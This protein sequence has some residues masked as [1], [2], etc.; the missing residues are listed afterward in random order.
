MNRET[1]GRGIALAAVAAGISGLAVFT[2]GM[3]PLLSVG[4][5]LTLLLA[6]L[7]Y[8][9]LEEPASRWASP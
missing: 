4:V 1:T 5:P 2:G 3:L 7:S 9:Y 8:H 6:A